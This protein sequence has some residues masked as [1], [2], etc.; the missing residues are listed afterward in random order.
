MTTPG[1]KQ[2][3]LCKQCKHG[4]KL[5]KQCTQ[6]H[7][8]S[9]NKQQQQQHTA[10]TGVLRRLTATSPKPD[11]LHC[12]HANGNRLAPG[13]PQSSR[14]ACKRG[15]GA[16]YASKA[17]KGSAHFELTYRAPRSLP[18]CDDETRFWPR[19]RCP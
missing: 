18:F 10:P 19:L 4:S 13:E 17:S 5:C 3:K 8:N 1:C 11:D 6:W 16:S 15:R 12:T 2:C 14:K 9:E 7:T